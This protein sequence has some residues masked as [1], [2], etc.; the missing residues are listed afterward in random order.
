MCAIYRAKQFVSTENV[1]SRIRKKWHM[2]WFIKGQDAAHNAPMIHFGALCGVLLFWVL[3][4]SPPQH[5]GHDKC[6]CHLWLGTGQSVNTR[7]GR[8]SATLVV[9]NRYYISFEIILTGCSFFLFYTS[10]QIPSTCLLVSVLDHICSQKQNVLN[11]GLHNIL[12][13]MN[14][15]RLIL[16]YSIF[17]KCSKMILYC[18]L[19]CTFSFKKQWSHVPDFEVPTLWGQQSSHTDSFSQ[20]IMQLF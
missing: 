8:K 18:I 12:T 4:P 15:H 11:W 20:L 2:K 5:L 17:F 6:K 10:Q 7:R 19:M 3:S 14:R 1:K 9:M 16:A 13:Q